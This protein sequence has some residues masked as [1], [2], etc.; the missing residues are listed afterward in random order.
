LS[1]LGISKKESAKWQK[2]AQPSNEAFEEALVSVREKSGELS[3]AAV[4]RALN[5]N[6]DSA[7]PAPDT[8]S[9]ITRKTEPKFDIL[10]VSRPANN[11][12]IPAF[13]FETLS[14][15]NK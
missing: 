8:K 14:E 5:R 15:R 11:F 12:T 2:L 7:K 9:K 6:G 1:D 10:L 13:H 3:E 4:V